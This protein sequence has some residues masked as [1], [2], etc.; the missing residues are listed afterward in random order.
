MTVDKPA[1]VATCIPHSI[2]SAFAKET[3][4]LKFEDLMAAATISP[5]AF[6]IITPNPTL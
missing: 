2:A 5:L 3:Y 6:L 1:L 4:P